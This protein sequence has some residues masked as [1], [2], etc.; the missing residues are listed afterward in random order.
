MNEKSLFAFALAVVII[1]L[2]P[3]P[4]MSYLA[5]LA[6]S[7]G[8]RAGLAATAGVAAGL[9]GAGIASLLGLAAI[10][11]AS[12]LIYEILRWGGVLYLLWLAWEG[13]RDA[14]E[15]IEEPVHAGDHKGFFLRG[16]ITNL[17]N[18]KAGLFYLSVFPAFIDDTRP[19]LAQTAIL[20]AI[21]V[22]IAT[23][24]HSVV[25]ISADAIRPTLEG[26]GNSRVVRRVL[27][28]SLILVAGWLFYSTRRLMP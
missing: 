17:L 14:P 26:R 2:T 15:G 28:T 27:S 9:L 18:P 24:I 11:A 4:N 19:L 10:V 21:Y 23:L 20:L 25:V 12:N 8:R 13:W 6:A 22:G 5:I 1:E 3:G 16:L 7:A